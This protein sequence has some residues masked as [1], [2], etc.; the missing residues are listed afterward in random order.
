MIKNRI[1]KLNK[2]KILLVLL[3][4]SI[5]VIVYIFFGLNNKKENKLSFNTNKQNISKE[6][7]DLKP[8]HIIIS[9]IGLNEQIYDDEKPGAVSEVF[10]DKGLSYYDENTNK[11]GQGNCVIFGHSA[12]TS[13]HSAPFEKIGKKELEKGDEIILTDKDNKKYTYEVSEVKIIKSNDF[14]VV[15]PTTKSIITLV[16]CIAPNFPKDTRIVVVG[17]LK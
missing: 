5:L 15:K 17:N 16:T 2:K 3:A 14:S 1:K 7:L 12:I 11:P 4:I 13:K 9:K 8:N 6:N 10:L